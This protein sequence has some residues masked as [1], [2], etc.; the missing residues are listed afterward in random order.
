[1]CVQ[2]GATGNDV[3]A[4]GRSQRHHGELEHKN[5]QEMHPPITWAAQEHLKMQ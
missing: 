3:I 4:E 5:I 1:M 2:T